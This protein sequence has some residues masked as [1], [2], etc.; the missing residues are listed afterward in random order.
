MD[1]RTVLAAGA[2][3]AA[4]AA[5]TALPAFGS[6]KAVSQARPAAELA[7]RP[8][9]LLVD[10]RE[11]AEWKDTGVLPNARLHSWRSPEDFVAALGAEAAQADEILILCRSGNRSG[12]AARALSDY[13]DREVVDVSGG[14]LRLAREGEARVVA[15]SARMGCASC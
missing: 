1:R 10:I 13:L 2:G 9:R 4:I 15:P 5:Y 11:P 8:G 12:K 14:M 7:P 3:L 6:S